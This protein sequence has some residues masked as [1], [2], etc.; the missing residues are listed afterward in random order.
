M[1]QC[2]AT[3]KLGVPCRGQAVQGSD[4]PLCNRHGGKP[5][6]TEPDARPKVHGNT[7][8]GRYVG[9]RRRYAERRRARE[10]A[11]AAGELPFEVD[12]KTRAFFR[13]IEGVILDLKAKQAQLSDFIDAN[14]HRLSCAD[15]VRLMATHD[16][17][18]AAIGTLMKEQQIEAAQT[19]P[20]REVFENALEEM[21]RDA[22]E[23]P[24][25]DGKAIYNLICTQMNEA[26]ERGE[27]V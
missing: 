6:A 17:L 8:H 21:A 9:A 27:L 25:M 19:T 13:T 14:F 4:P 15:R 12:P 1:V 7:K 3:T 23:F 18:I 2:T 11:E 24:G 10:A 26:I 20:I 16:R 22:G 5:R